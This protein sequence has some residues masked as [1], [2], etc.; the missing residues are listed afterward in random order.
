MKIHTLPAIGISL[1]LLGGQVR[2]QAGSAPAKNHPGHGRFERIKVHGK[3]LEGNLAGDSPDRDVSVYLPPT[4]DTASNRRY[5]VVYLLHGYTS[6]DEGWYGPKVGSGFEIAKTTLPETVDRAIVAGSREM[7]VV[8]PNAYNLYKGAMYSSS[9]TTGDWETYVTHDLVQ[10][11][12]SHYRTIPD[13]ASRGLAGHSMGG[14]GTI[15]LGMKHPEVYSSI[16]VLSACCLG[17]VVEPRMDVM[18]KVQTVHTPAEVASLDRG[19]IVSL[20]EAAAWSP[21]PNNPPLYFDLPVKDGVIQPLVLAKWHANAPLTMVPQYVFNLKKL[22]AIAIDVGDKDNLAPSNEELS[23]L[24]TSFGIAN[25]FETYDGDHTNRIPQRV[26]TKLMP[27][28]SEK[29]A[30][31]SSK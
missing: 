19:F 7:I 1:C 10:Y 8:M 16:F 3:S 9:V 13:R 20:G 4:Y 17:P 2:A 22:K 18:A 29:L 14:Y 12:D 15:R 28:F 30:F 6:S 24:L 25:S 11:I 23:K 21:N 27:F 31:A 26:E 5:P